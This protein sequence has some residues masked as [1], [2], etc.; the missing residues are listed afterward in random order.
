MRIITGKYRAKSIPT[1]K[2]F[3]DRPTTNFAKE[4]LFQL[5]R[6]RY[7]LQTIDVLDLFAGSGSISYEFVSVGAK[8]VTAVEKNSN[9]ARFMEKQI[10]RFFP[11]EMRVIT[12]DAYRI[13]EKSRLDYDV[14]FADPPYSDPN[15][16]Q[17]PELAFNNPNLKDDALLIVEHSEDTDFSE[18]PWLEE[19]RKYGK[20]RFSFFK[21]K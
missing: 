11:G 16:R 15:I 14:I 19:T 5:L 20:A 8:S 2:N 17:L 1:P 9:Y 3:R 18:S 7:D 13:L 4:G 21:K 10:A 12:S 6:N